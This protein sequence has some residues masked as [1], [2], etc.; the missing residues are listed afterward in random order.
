MSTA[1]TVRRAT[2]EE[3][4]ATL[5]TDGSGDSRNYGG[6]MKRL[7]V[8]LALLTGS[9][10]YQR[11]MVFGM[12][13]KS[14]VACTLALVLLAGS[15]SAATYY[16]DATD[17]DDD[18]TG[19]TEALAWQTI[20]KV[21]AASFSAGDS[22][23]F[24]RGEQWRETLT[25]PSSGESGNVIT[26]GAYGTGADPIISGAN[27]LT[28]FTAVTPSNI[29]AP[30]AGTDDNGGSNRQWREVIPASLITANASKI[31]LRY[32]ASSSNALTLGGVG[33]GERSGA[34]ADTTAMTRVTFG[35]QNTVT[36]PAGAYADS[37][38]I[39]IAIDETKDYV[40][41]HYMSLRNPKRNNS[42]TQTLYAGQVGVG[43]DESQLADVNDEL[44]TSVGMYG[45]IHAIIPVYDDTSYQ[46]AHTGE[47]TM[48]YE[49]DVRLTKQTTLHALYST[50]GSYYY[51]SNVVYVHPAGSDATTGHD[52]ETA[53][54]TV[55]VNTNEQSYL[56]I[57]DLKCW[58]TYG[59]ND[60]Y[61]NIWV[62]LG[63]NVTVRRCDSTNARRHPISF[64]GCSA[65][66]AEDC[67]FSDSAVTTEV[68]IY[69]SADPAP[70]STGN[71]L[72]RCTI[73]SL[74]A[75]GAPVVCHGRSENNIIEYCNLVSTA[76]AAC[77]VY[78]YDATASGL[79]VRYNTMGG[80]A[81]ARG[82]DATAHT[83]LQIYGNVI[84]YTG[85]WFAVEM[86]TCVGT[87]IYNN[88]IVSSSANFAI[89]H[90]GTNSGTI[91]KNN[92]IKSGKYISANAT[93]QTDYASDY[94]LY[95][96]GDATPFQWGAPTYNLAGWRTETSQDANSV[97]GDPLFRSATNLRIVS[98]SPAKDAGTDMSLATDRDGRA[99]PIGAA[100]DIGA[101]EFGGGGGGIIGGGIIH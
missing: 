53:E 58:K 92:I 3:Y 28:S 87:L 21:N 74:I 76:A 11:N 80:S 26:F 91:I 79:I 78:T 16:V 1:V 49:D 36:I 90:T 40:V 32:Y 46:A 71:I 20:A 12:F 10:G 17:G 67:T 70:K 27:V 45:I 41:H 61:G 35:G 6:T 34:L 96:G 44:Y 47:P 60:T 42:N 13:R 66:V 81:T 84:N 24:Q 4:S 77:W 65:C 43:P 63:S 85:I 38:A 37:D 93:S 59:D 29:F 88:T 99:I 73:T 100:P 62:N 7:L 39:T 86:D 19:L 5:T 2:D 31:K 97:A 48:V 50:A 33:I 55:N 51:A 98:G 25:V 56:A 75:S 94:N 82:I 18:A 54:R 72:R 22:I 14:I 95:Y 83:G 64:I 68:A 8:A 9:G 101:Y 89:Y 57:E 30:S 69:G 15:A 52:Y 23:L